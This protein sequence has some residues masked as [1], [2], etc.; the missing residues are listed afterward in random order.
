M[1]FSATREQRK[2]ERGP[3]PGV[4]LV[5]VFLERSSQK[6]RLGPSLLQDSSPSGLSIRMDQAVAVGKVLYLKNR[7]VRY[8]AHV[9]N[10]RAVDA[11]FRIGLEL[12]PEEELA[13]VG[14]QSRLE[15]SLL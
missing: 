15:P 11:G 14:A 5:D 3:A 8:T 6:V 13:P 9:R 1:P 4:G 7:Y 12:L 10:C 2:E